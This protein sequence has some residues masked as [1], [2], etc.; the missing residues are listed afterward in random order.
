MSIS[1]PMSLTKKIV[2]ATKYSLTSSFI[3]NKRLGAS[4]PTKRNTNYVIEW[5]REFRDFCQMEAPSSLW[6][7]MGIH[8]MNSRS[9]YQNFTLRTRW[10]LKEESE[11]RPKDLVSLKFMWEV[12]REKCRTVRST[13]PNHNQKDIY[14]KKLQGLLWSRCYLKQMFMWVSRGRCMSGK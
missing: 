12:P 4:N 14:L 5:Q 11:C 3:P 1:Y 8:W 7:L 9:N 2:A 10:I 6:K 13:T